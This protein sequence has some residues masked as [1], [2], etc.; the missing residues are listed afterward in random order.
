MAGVRDGVPTHCRRRYSPQFCQKYLPKIE[1]SFYGRNR[2]APVCLSICTLHDRS[3]GFAVWVGGQW[4]VASVE[5][6]CTSLD[7]V[8]GIDLR[9]YQLASAF[10]NGLAVGNCCSQQDVCAFAGIPSS[11][12]IVDASS[13]GGRSDAESDV[14]YRN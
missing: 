3:Y 7:A 9:P 4:C 8:V 11:S 10:C 6:S 5:Q 12:G 2:H 1:G 14:V 13:I